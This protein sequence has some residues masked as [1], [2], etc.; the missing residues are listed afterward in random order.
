MRRGGEGGTGATG[1]TIRSAFALGLDE[2]FGGAVVEADMV[3]GRVGHLH[4]EA[5]RVQNYFAKGGSVPAAWS[6]IQAFLARLEPALR[7][8]QS[9]V[10][11]SQLQLQVGD[12]GGFPLA[13]QLGSVLVASQTECG[14]CYTARIAFNPGLSAFDAKARASSRLSG[15]CATLQWGAFPS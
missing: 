11:W 4:R 7:P 6:G 13:Q 9:G 15:P 12:Q 3:F 2:R 1:R 14:G 10:V 8:E 5:R